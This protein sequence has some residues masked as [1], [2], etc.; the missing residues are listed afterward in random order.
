VEFP[1]VTFCNLNPIDYT[2]KDVKERIGE[3]IYP[4]LIDKDLV[5]MQMMNHSQTINMTLR[6]FGKKITERI[7][8]NFTK[9]FS[10]YSHSIDTMLLSCSFDNLPCDKNSFT[11]LTTAAFG[12]CFS[13]NYGKNLSNHDVPVA[14]ST[15]PGVENGLK[16]ELF[17]GYPSKQPFWSAESGILITIHNKSSR[18]LFIEEGIRIASGQHTNLLFTRSVITK[19][20]RPH[21]DCIENVESID[22]FDSPEYRDVFKVSSKYRRKICLNRCG[23]QRYRAS[24]PTSTLS[25]DNDCG[26]RDGDSA[27]KYYIECLPFCPE[28]CE[29]TNF[30]VKVSSTYYPNEK[31]LKSLYKMRKDH[32][33]MSETEE[34]LR[35]SLTSVNINFQT[36]ESIVITE[37]PR[38]NFVALLTNC[39]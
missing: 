11:I 27:R 29:K 9:S 28:E 7:Q 33:N 12:N 13:F 21:S 15:K 32:L 18:P 31:Y 16:L 25:N 36:T 17:S 34:E 14:K 35:K 8:N 4:L 39:G 23:N 6:R 10:N 22:A 26:F 19:L 2:R 24:L 30:D 1:A 20:S 5:E 3:M 38:M 37:S